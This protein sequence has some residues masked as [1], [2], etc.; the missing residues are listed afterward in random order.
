MTLAETSLLDFT[1]APEERRCVEPECGHRLSQYNK[2]SRCH[3]CD[4]KHR[5]ERM[6][7]QFRNAPL[8]RKKPV[9]SVRPAVTVS[10]RKVCGVEGCTRKLQWLNLNGR[11]HK[12]QKLQPNTRMKNGT[13]WMGLMQ[14]FV[15]AQDVSSA[16]DT[17][18]SHARLDVRMRAAEILAEER[19]SA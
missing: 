4:E 13:I 8:P 11:C 3:H 1:F 2:G 15:A 16:L 18:W 14:G 6:K 10:R 12:H 9:A 19:K 7:G 17:L 5:Q